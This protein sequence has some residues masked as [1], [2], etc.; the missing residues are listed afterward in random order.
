[1]GRLFDL[2]ASRKYRRDTIRR[3]GLDPR[4]ELAFIR[5]YTVERPKN[6]QL[7]RQREVVL[8]MLG[9][10]TSADEAARAELLRSE[11]DD[12]QLAFLDEPKN[13]HAWQYRHWLML[14]FAL[15]LDTELAFTTDMIRRDPY[16]NSAWNYRHSIRRREAKTVLLAQ[17]ADFI[18]SLARQ[19]SLRNNHAVLSYLHSLFGSCPGLFPLLETCD[20]S[21]AYRRLYGTA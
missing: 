1:M 2:C 19:Y 4:V 10:A 3:L 16:N 15:P 18:Q 13:Y 9:A 6:Y 5:Q 7:W 17:E 11:R 12:L 8:E 14:R 21:E 20:I